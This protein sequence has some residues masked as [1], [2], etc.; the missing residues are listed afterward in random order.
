MS[1]H[2]GS[3]DRCRC[4]ISSARFR[5]SAAFFFT[6]S[7][8]AGDGSPME[9]EWFSWDTWVQNPWSSPLQ[10]TE[11]QHASSPLPTR[12]AAPPRS[13]GIRSI[14]PILQIRKLRPQEVKKLPKVIYLVRDN[15]SPPGLACFAPSLP[16]AALSETLGLPFHLPGL[17]TGNPL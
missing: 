11:H 7:R 6:P 5:Y 2:G 17:L 12:P 1:S 4:K 15:T 9:R 14:L 16:F 3:W 8:R 13:L 10:F